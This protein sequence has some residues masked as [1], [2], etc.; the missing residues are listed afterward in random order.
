MSTSAAIN[1]AE[2]WVGVGVSGTCGTNMAGGPAIP[3][4]EGK[5]MSWAETPKGINYKDLKVQL[6]KQAYKELTLTYPHISLIERSLEVVGVRH[7]GDDIPTVVFI[8]Y[9]LH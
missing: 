6:E 1:S 7:I 4:G 5:I 9:L 2:R 3:R 8:I